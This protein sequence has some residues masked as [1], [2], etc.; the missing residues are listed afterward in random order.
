[1]EPCTTAGSTVDYSAKDKQL[2][3]KRA[4]GRATYLATQLNCQSLLSS[5][6]SGLSEIEDSERGKRRILSQGLQS[7]VCSHSKL[8]LE[9]RIPTQATALSTLQT[10]VFCCR[11][12]YQLLMLIL[13]GKWKFL[14]RRR[15]REPW[16]YSLTK[17]ES[18]IK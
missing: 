16:L 15:R 2:T 17:F 5:I 10:S 18:S 14:A 7:F 4:S 1:M 11:Q 3:K 9:K 13:S 8:C 6:L 12:F